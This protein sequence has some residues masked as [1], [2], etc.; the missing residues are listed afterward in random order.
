MSDQETKA[1][2]LAKAP[3]PRAEA[4][5]SSAN[6]GADIE[7][8]VGKLEGEIAELKTSQQKALDAVRDYANDLSAETQKLSRIRWIA[9]SAAALYILF[10]NAL[11]CCIIFYHKIYYMFFH[12]YAQASFFVIIIVSTT[13]LLLAALRGAF[14]GYADRHKENK[15]FEEIKALASGAGIAEAAKIIISHSSK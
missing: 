8:K 7:A 5:A 6:S 10:V 13:I 3:V 11:L 15:D 4:S 14:R 12:S 1:E 9:L 2:K